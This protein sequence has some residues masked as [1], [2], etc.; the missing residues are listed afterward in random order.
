[1]KQVGLW[2]RGWIETKR[3]L[4]SEVAPIRE[5]R[6]EFRKP[7]EK[8]SFMNALSR[9]ARVRVSRLLDQVYNRLRRGSSMR[10]RSLR[11]SLNLLAMDQ[12]K[13]VVFLS[14]GERVRL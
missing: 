6:E 10:A 2:E 3:G 12:L 4:W 14:V 11:R 9:H 13:L 8:E 1:M 7:D 5:E